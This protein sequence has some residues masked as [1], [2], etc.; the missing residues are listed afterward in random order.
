MACVTHFSRTSRPKQ[1]KGARHHTTK[2]STQEDHHAG[3]LSYTSIPAWCHSNLLWRRLTLFCVLRPQGGAWCEVC[4]CHWVVCTAAVR[5][6][7]DSSRGTT[8]LTCCIYRSWEALAALT[9]AQNPSARTSSSAEHLAPRLQIEAAY[10][11]ANKLHQHAGTCVS[12][13]AISVALAWQATMD[14]TRYH[15]LNTLDDI[16]RWL[17]SSRRRLFFL[18]APVLG[19]A[20]LSLGAV[21]YLWG[22]IRLFVFEWL[23]CF[24]MLSTHLVVGRGSWWASVLSLVVLLRSILSFCKG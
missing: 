6:L 3:G 20:L 19:T 9:V 16:E 13:S 12:L 7:V 2:A 17:L 1:K 21:Q 14:W 10:Q 18:R 11:Q 22:G 15:K 4:Q 23:R 5:N 8:H 24:I